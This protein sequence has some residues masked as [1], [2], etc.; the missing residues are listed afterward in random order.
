M[1]ESSAD[2]NKRIAKNTIF[3]YLRMMVMMSI[4]FFTSR[5]MLGALGVDDYGINNVVGGLVSMFAIISSSLSSATSRFLTFGLGKGDMKE[6]K[7]L[8]STSVNILL[9]IA[10]IVFVLIE[11]AGVWFLNNRMTIPSDRLY[12]ANWVL[13]C[14]ALNFA[15]SLLSTPYNASIV[16]HERMSVFAYM[17]IFDVVVKF[18]VVA[19]VYYYQGDRLVLMA[20]LLLISSIISQLIYWTYCKRNFEECTYHRLFSKYHFRKMFGFAGWNFIGCTAG[21]MKDQGVNIAINLFTGPTINAARGIAMQMNGIISQFTS[22]FLTAI[23][24]QVIKDYASGELEKM[25]MLVFRGTRF[26]YYLFLFLSVPVIFETE[27]ILW[28]WLGNVPDHTVLF[29]RLALVLSLSDLMSN[30]LITSQLATGKI[31]NYQI[32]VGGILLLNFPVSY[33]LLYLGFIPEITV[34]VAIAISQICLF[35]RLFFL[36]K[37]IMLP[38]KM[39]LQRVYLNVI[40][41]SAVS[42]IIPAIAYVNMPPDKTR[43][44][45]ICIIS[46]LS[47]AFSIGFLGCNKAERDMLMRYINKF[48]SRFSP[49]QAESI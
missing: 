11:T 22:N 14:S 29:A 27:K 18:I 30:L 43:F 24:P 3:L 47:S 44:F 10:F 49:R 37:M 19:S 32:V 4:S 39:Y 35:A 21:I 12:A 2:K 36:R 48:I 41:V 13:Q 17:T 33:L 5:I 7:I 46:A 25:H 6:L 8:F 23:N 38:V 40:L 26:S 1:S 16:A 20:S 31:R 15:V 34:A 28:L 42:M 45:C 9:L